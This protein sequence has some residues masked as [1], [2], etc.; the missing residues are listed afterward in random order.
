MNQFNYYNPTKI[1]FGAGRFNEL[2]NEI[3]QNANILLIYGQK[4]IKNNGIYFQIKNILNGYKITEFGGVCANPTY[5]YLMQAVS[6]IK[7]KNIDYILAV[8]GGSVIDGAKFISIAPFLDNPWQQIMSGVIYKLTIPLGVILTLPATGSEMN[9]SFV[10]TY[11]KNKD[12]RAF[13]NPPIFPKFSI[14]DPTVI[15]SLPK[16]QIA[17]G[18]IDSFVHVI[19]QYLTYPALGL[20][21][22]AFAESILKTLIDIGP[23]IMNCQNNYELNCNFMWCTSLALNGLIGVGVPQDWS[24]HMIGQE[25]TALYGIDHACSLAI[26]LPAVL[27]SQKENKAKKLIQYAKRVWDIHINN[28]EQIIDE[29]ILRTRVFFNSLGVKTSLHEYN[30]YDAAEIVPDKMENNKLLPIGE[31]LNINKDIVRKILLE[32]I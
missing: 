13:L 24:T 28:E 27:N 16:N 31:N 4:S 3:P 15:T 26:I 9:G 32:A 22:D 21:Q 23:K 6:I 7:E 1:I 10:I 29:V 11:E 30:I 17:N 14:L 5:E 20:L 18:I 12:K 2:Q 25:L 19:E 8:G